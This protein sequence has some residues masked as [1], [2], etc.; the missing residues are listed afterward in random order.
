MTG[1]RD[2]LSRGGVRKIIAWWLRT[3]IGEGGVFTIADAEKMI[4]AKTGVKRVEVDRRIRELREA[5]WTIA[6][7]RTDSTLLQDQHRL[8]HVGDDICDP[9][10][11]W[12][13]ARRCSARVR[14]IVFMRD[15]R[16]CVI[17]GTRDR[18]PYVD[19]PGRLARMTVGRILPGS[20]GGPYTT[21]NCRIECDRCNEAVQDRYDYGGEAFPPAA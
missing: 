20:R 10:Y 8:V 1:L 9:R 5:R 12:P 19:D 16:T 3:E 2:P 21:E 17:C 6:N 18:E 14:R 7:S 4:L 13:Q 15:G 11:R